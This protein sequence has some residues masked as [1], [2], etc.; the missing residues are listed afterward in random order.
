MTS[1]PDEVSLSDIS[2]LYYSQ[3]ISR[4]TVLAVAL[5]TR[6]AHLDVLPNG[7]AYGVRVDRRS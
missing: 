2:R 5:I 3:N 4:R 1:A 6:Q 7:L